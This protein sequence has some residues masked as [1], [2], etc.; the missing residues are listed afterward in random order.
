[1]LVGSGGGSI[2]V[3]SA[4]LESMAGQIAN[5][6][7]ATSSARG[8]FGGAAGSAG[9]CQDPAAGSFTMLQSLLSGALG[10]LDDCSALLSG[11]TA[12][13]AAAYAGTDAAQMPGVIES[14]PA[15]P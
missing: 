8:S 3:E 13:A 9:G 15:V 1:M 2:S 4:A 11:N 10:M 7:R 6:A 5:V 14:C 12:S